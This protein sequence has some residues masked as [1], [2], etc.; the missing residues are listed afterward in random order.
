MMAGGVEL[1]VLLI[2]HCVFNAMYKNVKFNYS[3]LIWVIETVASLIQTDW[4]PALIKNGGQS[5]VT[6]HRK[7]ETL[8][9]V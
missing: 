9:I 1:L 4:S 5:G 6:G 3:E 7:F 2:W 8:L